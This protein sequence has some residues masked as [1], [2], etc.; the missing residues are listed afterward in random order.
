M[1]VANPTGISSIFSSVLPNPNN[2]MSGSD[3]DEWLLK[4]IGSI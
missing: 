1:V 4:L 3:N 2:V